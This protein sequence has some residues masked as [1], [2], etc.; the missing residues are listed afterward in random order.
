MPPYQYNSMMTQNNYEQS[1]K[2]II[3]QAN[4][5]LQQIKSQPAPVMPQQPQIHQS[6]QLAP[7]A[8][9]TDIQAKYVTDINDVRNTFVANLGLFI[10]K[11]NNTLWI[12]N[13]NGDIRSFELKE[14]VEQDPKDIEIQELKRELQ[15]MR[16][17]IDKN[18]IKEEKITTSK[19]TNKTSKK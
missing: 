10:N 8:S 16:L 14:I 6:F 15:N 3:N 19:A 18:E 13:L 11:E 9:S 17:L 2:N 4:S 12:K 7:Q 5:Q 1:L